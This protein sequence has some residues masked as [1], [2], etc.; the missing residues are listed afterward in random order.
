MAEIQSKQ[1]AKKAAGGKLS[2]VEALGRVQMVSITT[3]DAH[4]LA[5]NDTLASPI[6]L[7]VGTRFTGLGKV[8][9]AA[10]GAGVTLNV[11]IREV[12]GSVI[13]ADGIASA[14]SVANAGV[15]DIN[16]GAFVAAG[17]D[18]VTTVPSVLFATL[19]GANPNDNAQLRIDVAVV[20]PG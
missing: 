2:N 11:G 17:A 7:P 6:V 13:D 18:Y 12:D 14:V 10:M 15:T 16:N 4:A 20:L 8:S 3:P 1:A 5:Q 9:R 19:D